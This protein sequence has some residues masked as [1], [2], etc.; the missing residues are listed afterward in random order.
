[1]LYRLPGLRTLFPRSRNF[2]MDTPHDTFQPLE[3]SGLFFS[4]FY[5]ITMLISA[6]RKPYYNMAEPYFIEENAAADPFLQF[7][8]WFKDVCA[9]KEIS[10]EEMNAVSNVSIFVLCFKISRCAFRHVCK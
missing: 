10:Y 2:L 7:D 1:M 9:H 3:I 4:L 5:L 6:Y 8:S